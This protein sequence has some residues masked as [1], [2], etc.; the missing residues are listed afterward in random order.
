MERQRGTLD[1]A[2]EEK[3]ARWLGILNIRRDDGDA[4]KT[5]AW[6]RVW[7]LNSPMTSI[8]HPSDD[9]PR[10]SKSLLASTW[11]VLDQVFFFSF[12]PLLISLIIL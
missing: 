10:S 4:Q 12:S 6:L 7:L 8:S 3:I 11:Q 5:L 9:H 1:P 2:S